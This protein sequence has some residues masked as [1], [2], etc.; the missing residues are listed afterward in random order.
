MKLVVKMALNMKLLEII[1][2]DGDKNQGGER[3]E[4]DSRESRTQLL[5]N[6][7]LKEVMTSANTVFEQKL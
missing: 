5:E 7:Q 3:Y 6:K 4:D 1:R 2:T